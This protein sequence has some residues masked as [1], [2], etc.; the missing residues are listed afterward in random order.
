MNQ[1]WHLNMPHSTA[2]KTYKYSI[3]LFNQLTHALGNN[4]WVLIIIVAFV[5]FVMLWIILYQANTIKKYK[6][7]ISHSIF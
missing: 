5:F 6:N 4:A 3:H 2:E 7:E 1:Q